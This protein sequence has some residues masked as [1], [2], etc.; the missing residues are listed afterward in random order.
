[1]DCLICCDEKDHSIGHFVELCAEKTLEIFSDLDFDIEIIYT[2]QLTAQKIHELTNKNGDRPFICAAY[3][4][5]SISALLN[6]SINEDY[7]STEINQASF[8]DVFFYTWACSSGYQLG[9]ELVKNKCAVYIGHVD[10]ISV[11]SPGDDLIEIFVECAVYGLKLF[12]EE[13][14]SAQRS[15]NEMRDLYDEKF[16]ELC[17]SEPLAAIFLQEH[18]NSLDICGNGNFTFKDLC[19]LQG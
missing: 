12:Y 17:D 6:T 3:S 8:C 16:D 1:M 4:H 5:G 13:G 7:V 9:E 10:E 11:P 19:N 18:S 15:L 14:Y 2:S